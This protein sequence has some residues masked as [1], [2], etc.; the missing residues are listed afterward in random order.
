[1]W[2]PYGVRINSLTKRSAKPRKG[3]GLGG[4]S[5]K[6]EIRAL[7]D[8]RHQQLELVGCCNTLQILLKTKLSIFLELKTIKLAVD[9][10][11]SSV[12]RQEH[13]KCYHE[14]ARY[15]KREQRILPENTWKYS[16][17]ITIFSFPSSQADA[18]TILGN[19]GLW[20]ST[21]TTESV[22][23]ADSAHPLQLWH[24]LI[25]IMHTDKCRRRPL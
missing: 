21:I 19:R 2:S 6:G 25:L 23:A 17:A 5:R 4:R 20:R 7:V 8:S 11:C 12:S 10:K 14:H 16:W 24:R 13:K 18:T 3:L 15:C 9:T 22:A 1:M